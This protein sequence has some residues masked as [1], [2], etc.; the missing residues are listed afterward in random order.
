M[1]K[2]VP[3]DLFNLGQHSVTECIRLTKMIHLSRDILNPFDRDPLHA[4]VALPLHEHGFLVLADIGARDCTESQ[5]RREWPSGHSR[6]TWLSLTQ[7]SGV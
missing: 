3:I 4:L 6:D 1:R 5:G 2:Y 7:Y